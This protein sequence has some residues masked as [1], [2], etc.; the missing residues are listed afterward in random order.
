MIRARTVTAAYKAVVVQD[1][2]LC[3]QCLFIDLSMAPVATDYANNASHE[4]ERET[5][6][7]DRILETILETKTLPARW[8]RDENVFQLEKRAIFSKVD[9][10]FS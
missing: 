9:Y 1:Q 2:R 5:A 4:A 6:L 7:G 3:P 10:G 8:M